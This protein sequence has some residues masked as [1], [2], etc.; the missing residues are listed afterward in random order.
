MLRGQSDGG[1]SPTEAPD[2]RL[3]QVDNK[4]NPLIRF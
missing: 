2:S 4:S 1:N 3:C